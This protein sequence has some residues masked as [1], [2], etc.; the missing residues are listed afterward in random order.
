M[1]ILCNAEDR[2]DE[3][4]KHNLGQAVILIDFVIFDNGNEYRWLKGIKLVRLL[5]MKIR[6]Q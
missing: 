5:K 1:Y 3:F 6:M 4:S 2:A